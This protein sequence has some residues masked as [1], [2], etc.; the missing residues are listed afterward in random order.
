MIR[1]SAD[2]RKEVVAMLADADAFVGELHRLSA[3]RHV[4]IWGGAAPARAAAP[5]A[6]APA[7]TTLR[8]V[9][10]SYLAEHP[11]GARL[12]QMEQDLGMARIKL[13]GEIRSLMEDQKIQKREMLYFAA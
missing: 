4:D 5:P 8:D 2:R 11:D 13:A 10:F 6:A 12:A 3:A 1:T 9:I 7:G